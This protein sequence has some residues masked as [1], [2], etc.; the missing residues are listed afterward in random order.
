MSDHNYF[1]N[2]IAAEASKLD[3]LLKD[4]RAALLADAV[5]GRMG[6]LGAW[7]P[8]DVVADNGNKAQLPQ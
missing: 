5:S 6:A 8:S 3:T 4:R 2:L 7:N 1:A